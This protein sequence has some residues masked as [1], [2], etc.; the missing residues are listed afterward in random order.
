MAVPSL[1]PTGLFP[2]DVT[3]IRENLRANLEASP[4]YGPGTAFG[5]DSAIG[6]V[7]D[8]TAEEISLGYSL[9]QSIYDQFSLENAVGIQLDNLGG[10]T[11]V[12]REP[13]TFSE[14]TQTLLGTPTTVI[15]AGS[16]VKV[17]G[18][19][20]NW[21]TIAEATIDG[22]GTV[23]VVVRALSTGPIEGGAGTI[24]EIVTSVPGW[25]STTNALDA[26][27]GQNIE[28]D[29]RYRLR[30]KRSRSISGTGTDAAIGARVE[31]L[32]FVDFA[33]PLSNRTVNVV[34]G[35]DGNSIQVYVWPD[36]LTAAQQALVAEEI[37]GPAGLTAGIQ[38]FGTQAFLITD[39]QGNPQPVAFS[40][41]AEVEIHF[42]FDVLKVNSEF[43][44]DGADLIED[45]TVEFFSL[46]Q[47]VGTDVLP[48]TLGCFILENIPGIEHMRIRLRIGVE[49][50]ATDTAPI[51]I[52]SFE[53]ATVLLANIDVNTP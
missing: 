32:D 6:G 13:A 35:Q 40:F 7:I 33:T 50:G 29:A 5:P 52:D 25:T 11:G 46:F 22:G 24:T 3:D 47:G 10:V 43:P 27:L 38:A 30:I 16:Q 20:V 31:Q 2:L 49:P 8:V 15:A 53:I 51:P 45:F 26:S 1:D 21:E 18:A 12:I 23:D 48:F 19:T 4:A 36:T 39:K 14:V 41:A 42:V 28:S 9:D 37:W 17:P 44:S 34:N